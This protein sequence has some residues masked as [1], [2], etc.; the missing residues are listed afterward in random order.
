MAVGRPEITIRNFAII[1][2]VM[3]VSFLIG[4]SYGL[5]GLAYSWL[6]C[7]VVSLFTTSITLR[8][9]GLSLA[10]YFKVLRHP[11]FGTGFMVLAVLLAQKLVLIDY[12]LGAQAAGSVALGVASYFLYYLLFNREMF[13]EARRM[14][15]R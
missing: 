2:S 4:S 13:A 10:A 12:G 3:A 14:L 7:P 9:V 1:V 8:L 5:D 11:V 6:V 15:K